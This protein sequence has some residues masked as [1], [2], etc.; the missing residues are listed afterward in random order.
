MPVRFRGRIGDGIQLED[1]RE[2]VVPVTINRLWGCDLDISDQ[3]LTLTIDRF[4]ERYIEPAV[5]RI[6]NMIDGEGLDLYADVYNLAQLNVTPGVTPTTR[7]AYTAAG[8]TLSNSGAPYGSLRALVVSPE[9]EAAAIEFGATLFNPPKTISEQY[10]SGTMGQALGF[11]WSMDQNVS[12]ATVG[13]AGGT[14]VVNGANQTGSSLITSGW[15]ASTQV[16]NTGD[17]IK[18]AGVNSVNPISYRD[19][20]QL[21]TFVVGPNCPASDGSGNL[22]IPI[23]PDINIDVTSPFQT[24]TQSPANNAA[25]FVY[26][27]AAAN[28]ANI[29]GVSSPQAL[30]FHRD[31]FALA[32]VNLELPGGLD[33]SE[34]IS[35]PKVGISMRL[36]RGFDMRTNRRYTRLEAFGGWKTLRPEFACRIAG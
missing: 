16:L 22:T 29:S 12:R 6:A 23:S 7:T 32:I 30:A 36:T 24:V 34:R 33:W 20:G 21:R 15:T 19:T 35:N 17:I 11:K 13:L 14:P 2:T 9:M 3:D 5:Q 4:G 1:I 27:T 31:A 26:N 10:L 28:L 8:V 25:I 18:V